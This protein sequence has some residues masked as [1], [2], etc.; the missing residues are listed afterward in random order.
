MQREL[1]ELLGSRSHRPARAEQWSRGRWARW[2]V[3]PLALVVTCG[4]GGRGRVQPGDA[5]SCPSCGRTYGTAE[6][7]GEEYAA[8][9]REVT[10]AKLRAL[11]GFGVIVAAFLP[12]GF[13]LGAELWITGAVL[14]A[15][16]YFAYGP[17]LK[18]DVRR[19]VGDL[20]RWTVE[21]RDDAAGED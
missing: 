11:T 14:L 17:K 21:E 13:L 10:R 1:S 15:V 7:P 6:I 19:M 4:C 16:F 18:R 9:G 20:P 3:K 12:L 5:W 2:S 8:V